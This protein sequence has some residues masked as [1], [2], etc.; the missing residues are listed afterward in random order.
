MRIWLCLELRQEA[1]AAEM[2]LRNRHPSQLH[3]KRIDTLGHFPAVG[4]DTPPIVAT[5]ARLQNAATPHTAAIEPKIVEV[6]K[7]MKVRVYPSFDH[8][9]KPAQYVTGDVA[10]RA[11][12]E[13][14]P[15]V[16]DQP[17]TP[18]P[19]AKVAASPT[20]D[21]QVRQNDLIAQASRRLESGDVAGAREL[22][23]AAEDDTQ[24]LV[25][26][27]LAETYDP[28]ML[29]AWGTQGV[30][31]DVARAQALYRKALSLGSAADSDCHRI[32]HRIWFGEERRAFNAGKSFQHGNIC[33]FGVLFAIGDMNIPGIAG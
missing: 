14:L 10:P 32:W 20:P 28:N 27:A 1:A 25:A 9:D 11:T 7:T 23:A 18:A 33:R 30:A 17:A 29:A 3:G 5:G 4:A 8:F 19:A 31:A 16:T 26:F 15:A 6:S 22:L 21:G 24:G 12:I 13:A 2:D